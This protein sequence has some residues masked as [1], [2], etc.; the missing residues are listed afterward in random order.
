[1]TDEKQQQAASEPGE[2]PRVSRVREFMTAKF[3]ERQ[4]ADDDEFD[5][6]LA[7]HLS[8]ADEKIKGNERANKTIMEV[9]EAYPEFAEI[10]E[11]IA[12]GVPVNVALARQF[13]PEDLAVGEGEQDYEAYK[14]AAAERTKRLSDSKERTAARER[15]MAQSKT[16][17]DAFFD[18][19]GMD[20]AE[21]EQFVAW[22]D[23]EI[24]ANLLDGKV[25]KEIL[26]KLY[27]G[28]KFDEAVT[29]ARTAGEVEGRNAQIEAKRVKAAKTDGLPG[30]GSGIAPEPEAEPRDFMDEVLA[31]KAKRKF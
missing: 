22:V 11:D 2:A 5:N 14:K 29:D 17:V 4:W 25:N 31:R 13:S 21:R 28:W 27:Q 3:P 18:E 7:D 10:I 1:M 6:A 16:D 30:G 12:G 9:I 8:E 15:N 20:E 26:T 23:N 19:K 24:L